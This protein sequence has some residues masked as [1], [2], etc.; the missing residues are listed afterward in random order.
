MS[1]N[2]TMTVSGKRFLTLPGGVR[3]CIRG[4][5]A[6]SFGLI[7]LLLLLMFTYLGLWVGEALLTST[8]LANLKKADAIVMLG[9]SRERAIDADILF[10]RRLAPIVIISGGVEKEISALLQLGIPASKIVIDSEARSTLDHPW[11]LLSIPF[12]DRDSRLILVTSEFHQYRSRAVFERAGFQNIQ[13][14]SSQFEDWEIRQ[15]SY[16][17]IKGAAQLIYELLAL[18]KYA[19]VGAI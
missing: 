4:I 12:I 13:I 1:T 5:G 6:V 15:S 14:Y 9:G 8:Q 16:L 11:T 10:D 18:G 2:R 17:G 19:V 7:C 3:A